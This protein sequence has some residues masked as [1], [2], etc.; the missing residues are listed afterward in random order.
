MNFS[1]ILVPILG[2]FRKIVFFGAFGVL[3]TPITDILIQ[4]GLLNSSVGCSPIW[5]MERS[6]PPSWLYTMHEETTY[7]CREI[8]A[9]RKG[10][11]IHGV[12]EHFVYI[13]TNYLQVLVGFIICN[14]LIL[15][16]LFVYA[17][18]EFTTIIRVL[19]L[20]WFSHVW[21]HGCKIMAELVQP[22]D[23][24]LKRA[25]PELQNQC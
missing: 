10:I 1:A 8:E 20:W 22:R 7:Y 4:F 2:S 13:M 3:Q 12:S 18:S 25:L 17:R 11:E 14:L 16:T 15:I 5:K 24:E 6:F 21:V 9:Q 23:L 19:I